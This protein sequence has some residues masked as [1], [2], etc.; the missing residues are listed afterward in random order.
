MP[1]ADEPTLPVLWLCGPPGVGKSSVGWRIYDR[2][3]R[4]GVRAAYLDIDQLGICY[5]EPVD[6]PGRHGLK[7][8]NLAAVC[9]N[10]ATAGARGVVVSGV[11]DAGGVAR[12]RHVLPRVVTWCLL[13]A[14]DA[15]IRDRFL[16]RGD[17]PGNLEEVL[18]EAKVMRCL[19][20]ELRVDTRSLSIDEVVDL[21]VE[22]LGGWPLGPARGSSVGP[23]SPF[24]MDVHPCGRVVWVCGP[25]GV[26]K[27]VAAYGYYRGLLS[28]GVTA[29]YVDS[30]QL[31]FLPDAT[32]ELR[33]QNL[34]ALW[35]SFRAVGATDLVVSGP[36]DT[37]ADLRRYREALDGEPIAVCRL[38]AGPDALARR[39]ASRAAGHGW[40]QPGDPISGRTSTQLAEITARA[41][42]EAAALER[43]DFGH[44]VDTTWLDPAQAVDA[45]ARAT[46]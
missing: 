20:V 26:G 31:G 22:R 3:I 36:L 2:C 16:G 42:A 24:P 5:P 39:I 44:R 10:F 4:S 12:A 11:I 17:D 1:E 8:R 18:T 7:T 13:T 38:H 14:D 21:V 25:T 27:S 15:T 46:G 43:A 30:A 32:H 37:P 35:R 45:I 19:P 6:D 9:R 29:A 33:A 34:G 40:A 28:Q 23:P 41:T